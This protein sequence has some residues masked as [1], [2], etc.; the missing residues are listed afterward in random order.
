MKKNSRNKYGLTER[1]MKTI[2]D[3]FDKYPDVEEVQ[4]CG[5]RVK[6]NYKPGSDIDLVVMNVGLA[7]GTIGK[8]A[9]DI[10]ESSL[11]YTVDIVDFTSL[12]HK[13]FI[14]HIERVGVVFYEKKEPS[15]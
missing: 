14:D 2:Q 4:I 15:F 1:D 3:I 12:K 11:P 9:T 8:L 13:E 10:E 7:M 5:S 6:G